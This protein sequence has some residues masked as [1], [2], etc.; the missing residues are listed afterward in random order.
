MIKKSI[1]GFFIAILMLSLTFLCLEVGVRLYIGD[2]Q[3]QLPFANQE[4]ILLPAK[5]KYRLMRDSTCLSKTN[6]IQPRLFVQPQNLLS[7]VFKEDENGLW[8]A[9]PNF[10]GRQRQTSTLTG[11]VMFDVTYQIDGFG[12]R[13]APET[14]KPINKHSILIGCSFVFGMGLPDDQTLAAFIQKKIPGSKS[15]NITLPG[16]SVADVIASQ[17][18]S[19]MWE[20]IEPREGIVLFNYSYAMHMRRFLGTI[21][22]IGEYGSHRAYLEYDQNKKKYIY[23]GAYSKQKRFYVLIANLLNQSK[24]LRFIGFDWPRV[25]EES[26]EN[27]ARA[28]LQV[29]ENYINL[30]G[31]KNQF[32]VYFQPEKKWNNLIPYLEKYKIHYLDYTDFQIT[33]YAQSTLYIPNDGHPTAEYNRLLAEQMACDLKLVENKKNLDG[34]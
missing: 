19:R 10:I 15:Y 30:Y 31:N 28:I 4:R 23:R 21:V 6:F 25:T 11:E 13:V 26:L 3:L 20:G 2:L 24:F 32:V 33:N 29:K 34:L 12:R 16:W 17:E 14:L 5:S 18:K 8:G 27:Y 9:K 7:D 22:S 1:I